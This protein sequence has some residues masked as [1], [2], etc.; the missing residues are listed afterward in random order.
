MGGSGRTPEQEKSTRSEGSGPTPHLTDRAAVAVGTDSGDATPDPGGEV[1]GGEGGQLQDRP[2]ASLAPAGRGD[3]H[4][5][6]GGGGVVQEP[7]APPLPVVAPSVRDRLPLEGG[8]SLVGH[9]HV[10]GT[11]LGYGSAGTIVFEGTF[12]GGLATG[13]PVNPTNCDRFVCREL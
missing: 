11:V 8:G 1:G 9:I 5:L 4:G 3:G 2:A 6:E 12:N 13:T 10:T 7:P